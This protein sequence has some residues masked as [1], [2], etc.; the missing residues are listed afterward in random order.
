MPSDTIGT[1]KEQIMATEL[2]GLLAGNLSVSGGARKRRGARLLHFLRLQ[3]VLIAITVGL[4]V[5]EIVAARAQPLAPVFTTSESVLKSAFMKGLKTTEALR[6]QDR[7]PVVDC[8][9][10]F[11]EFNS[12]EEVT[13]YVAFFAT[14]EVPVITDDRNNRHYVAFQLNYPQL[15]TLGFDRFL[16]HDRLVVVFTTASTASSQITSFEVTLLNS[17]HL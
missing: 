7:S 9:K 4:S 17:N 13:A 10:I 15:R 8:T 1:P 3:W 16:M 6:Q 11:R 5:T 2:A 14:L 12:Q